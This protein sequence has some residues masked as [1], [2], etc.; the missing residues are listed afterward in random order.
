MRRAATC[1]SRTCCARSSIWTRRPARTSRHRS[2]R[3]WRPSTCPPAARP[4]SRS[5]RP[6]RYPSQRASAARGRGLPGGAAMAPMRRARQLRPRTRPRP[7]CGAGSPR[8]AARRLRPRGGRGCAEIGRHLSRGRARPTCAAPRPAARREP[9]TPAPGCRRSA[10]ARCARAAPTAPRRRRPSR[11]SRVSPRAHGGA[12]RTAA[13][14]MTSALFTPGTAA[15]QTS[16]CATAAPWRCSRLIRAVF[17]RTTAP[18]RLPSDL[19]GRS[20]YSLDE[21]AFEMRLPWLQGF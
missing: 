11:R 20:E 16:C 18:L 5:V 1:L 9:A 19:L 8:C 15:R 7:S 3:P 14:P 4:P 21:D 12:G 17:A 13:G 10:S 6:A 2:H